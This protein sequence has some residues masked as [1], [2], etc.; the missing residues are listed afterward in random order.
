MP[1][2]ST[3][4][5]LQDSAVIPAH[6]DLAFTVLLLNTDSA[7]NPLEHFSAEEAG[8]EKIYVINS[9]LTPV[10]AKLHHTFAIRLQPR[11]CLLSPSAS[12]CVLNTRLEPFAISG[13][14]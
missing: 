12:L 2:F 8:R 1:L 3:Q 9:H 14:S 6:A 13:L 5:H 11:W 10:V 7:G 4:S